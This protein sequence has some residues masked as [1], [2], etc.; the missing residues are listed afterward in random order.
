M[1]RTMRILFVG[2][3]VGKPGRK[4]FAEIA[5]PMKSA[6]DVD[7]IV[8]N[9]EN[10]AGGRGPSPKILREIFERGAD[11]ITLGDHA[12]D[13]KDMKTVIADDKRILRPANFPEVCPGRG[14]TTVSNERGNLTVINLIGRVFMPPLFNCPFEAAARILSAPTG[15]AAVKLVD[16]HAEATSEKIAMGRHLEGR[17]TAV[18][19]THTHVQTSDN[20]IL[21]GGTAYIT[22]VGMTGPKDSVI[23]RE[24][25]PVLAKFRTGMPHRFDVASDDI[26]LEGVLIEADGSSGKAVSIERIRIALE[27]QA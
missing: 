6:G 24:V 19:G 9:A 22:D 1:S 10:S 18:V 17:V 13:D 15:M 3:I 27:D 14:F 8:A 4:A 21:P 25:Q 5:A 20:A 23:G 16:F 7:F 11:V 12:W 26:M 2:D